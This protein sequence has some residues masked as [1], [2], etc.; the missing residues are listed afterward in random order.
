[1]DWLVQHR[2]SVERWL[3]RFDAKER[4]AIVSIL[5]ATGHEVAAAQY[6][7]DSE[8]ARSSLNTAMPYC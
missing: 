8:D 5:K 2:H 3:R 6:V 1:L 7:R 4:D